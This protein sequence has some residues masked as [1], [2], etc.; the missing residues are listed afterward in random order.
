MG[1]GN[2][3][4]LYGIPQKKFSRVMECPIIGQLVERRTWDY[5]IQ[6]AF[7]I[8]LLEYQNNVNVVQRPLQHLGRINHCI[9]QRGVIHH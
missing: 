5:Y 7:F 9:I 4:W 1:A 8:C 6:H 2:K 3:V